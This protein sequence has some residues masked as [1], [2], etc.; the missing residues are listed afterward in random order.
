[1]GLTSYVNEFGLITCIPGTTGMY[2]ITVSGIDPSSL[3][4]LLA[5]KVIIPKP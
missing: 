5:I 2:A 3:K 4:K 1:M